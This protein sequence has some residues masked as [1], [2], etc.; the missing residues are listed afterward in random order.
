MF[1]PGKLACKDEFLRKSLLGEELINTQFHLF[2]ARSSPS[3][4]VTK[5]RILCANN[6]LLVKSSKYFSDREW[7]FYKYFLRSLV[8]SSVEL[9]YNSFRPFLG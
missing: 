9:G 8:A 6:V 5:P 7:L 4:R 2:S 1:Y 3:G